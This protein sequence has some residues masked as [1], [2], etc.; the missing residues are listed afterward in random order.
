MSS[1]DIQFSIFMEYATDLTTS[2]IYRVFDMLDVD[3]SGNIDF[4]EF[5]LLLSILVAAQVIFKRT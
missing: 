1:L 5:Y 2:E 3:G 4:N